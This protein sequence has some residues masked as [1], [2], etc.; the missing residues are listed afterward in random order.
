MSRRFERW[1]GI[2]LRH[3]ETFHAV[4]REQSFSQGAAA[5]GYTQSAV[6]HQIAA[7]ERIV[8]ARLFER[9]G[10]RRPITLTEQGTLLL[11]YADRVLTTVSAAEAEMETSLNGV[12]RLRIGA[13][14]SVSIRVL[15]AV[16]KYFRAACPTTT[17]ELTEQAWDRDLLQGV[18]DGQLDLSFAALPLEEGPFEFVELLED[19]LVLLAPAEWRVAVRGAPVTLEELARLPIIAFRRCRRLAQLEDDMRSRSLSPHFVYRSDD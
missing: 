15:P 1:L 19:P 8:G 4:A 12:G 17:V 10:G 13:F 11:G 2:E 18:A 3:L 6:S 16:L 14:Q 5:L 7:L 9:P